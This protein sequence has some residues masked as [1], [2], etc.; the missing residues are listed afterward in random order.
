MACLVRVPVPGR[1]VKWDDSN[2][3]RRTVLLRVPQRCKL[4]V[5][6]A[7]HAAFRRIR[8]YCSI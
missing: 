8:R 6:S 1:T 3:D 7:D 2:E 4:D 5:F